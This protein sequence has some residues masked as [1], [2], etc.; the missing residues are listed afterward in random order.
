[1]RRGPI[2]RIISLMKNSG[3]EHRRQLALA[4]LKAI[5]AACRRA[6]ISPT[7]LA[8]EAGLAH[9]IVNRKLSGDDQSVIKP[10]TLAAIEEAASR[11]IG[12]PIGSGEALMA[13]LDATNHDIAQQMDDLVRVLLKK[14]VLDEADLPPSLQSA[15]KRR[16]M[17]LE[18]LG[19]SAE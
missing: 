7:R 5:V 11:M 1:M 19:L 6:G 8:R 18:L 17:L 16:R 10:Q 14:Q 9:N 13:E 15:I 12:K 4:R 3:L 2:P